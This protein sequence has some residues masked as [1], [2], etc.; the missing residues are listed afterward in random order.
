VL[1]SLQ[2]AG[3]WVEMT[4]DLSD[5]VAA[6]QHLVRWC[7]KD[8]AKHRSL[9]TRPA[10][11]KNEWGVVSSRD[12]ALW[13]LQGLEGIGPDAAAKILDHFGG[14]PIRWADGVGVEQLCQVDGIG[15]PTAEKLIVALGGQLPPPKPKRKRKA[16]SIGP[17]PR[18][19][20]ERG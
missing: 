14:M 20:P 17:S 10:A 15:K 5:T 19:V 18:A 12:Y 3:I 9:V 11:P 1:R 13:F 8:R 7:A 6:V 16:A 2:A 4:D